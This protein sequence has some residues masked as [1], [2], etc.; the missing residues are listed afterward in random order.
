ME[1]MN[2]GLMW[3]GTVPQRKL[4]ISVKV[5]IRKWEKMTTEQRE[6]V[7]EHRAKLLQYLE[8][9]MATAREIQDAIGCDCDRLLGAMSREGVLTRV[10]GRPKRWMINTMERQQ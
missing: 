3:G 5:R 2:W 10:A 9:R 4:R 6:L 7:D 1:S 8:G